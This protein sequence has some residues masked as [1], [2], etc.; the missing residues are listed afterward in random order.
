MGSTGGPLHHLLIRCTVRVHVH[1]RHAGTGFF[2]APGRV[3]TCAHVVA[4]AVREGAPVS[5]VWQA[6]TFPAEVLKVLPKVTDASPYPYPD[7]A[8]LSVECGRHPC[9][10]LG[11]GEPELGPPP[12]SLWAYGFTKELDGACVRGTPASFAYEGPVPDPIPDEDGPRLQLKAA[13]VVPGMS[14]APLLNWRTGQVCGIVT[15]TRDARSD[16][17]GWAVPVAAALEQIDGL[18]QAHDAFHAEDHEWRLAVRDRRIPTLHDV[19]RPPFRPLP[20]GA[21]RS[22]SVVLWPEHGVVAFRGRHDEL[23][24][25]A[26][27]CADPAAPAVRL[28]VGPGGRGKS[29]LAAELC[30]R[31]GGRGW[32]AGLL[33][34]DAADDALEHVRQLGVP[35]LVVIDYAETRGN[36]AR[37]LACLAEDDPAAPVRVLLLAREA[38]D[39]WRELLG[40][41]GDVE[42]AVAGAAVRRLGEV[43]ETVEGRGEAFD[44]AVQAFADAQGVV[45]GSVTRPPLSG[46]TFTSI[47]FVHL[48]ALDALDGGGERAAGTAGK[49]R[50][51]LLSSLLQREARFWAGTARVRGLGQLADRVLRRAVAVATLVGADGE[52]QAALLLAK[53]PDLCDASQALLR[54]DVAWWLHDLYPGQEWLRPLQPDLLGETLVA[55]VLRECPELAHAV[56]ADVAGA[57][58]ERA[59]TVLGRAARH[60]P[61]A[62]GTLVAVLQSDFARL[63]PAALTVAVQVGD[64][65]G[66]AL[67]EAARGTRP[68]PALC[69][70]LLDQVPQYTV[71]LRELAV[72]LTEWLLQAARAAG[73]PAETARLL[74]N[75]SNRLADL[76]RHEQ[77]LDAIQEAAALHR[78]LAETR[79]DAFTPD[80]ARSLNNLSGRLADLGRHEQALAARQEAARITDRP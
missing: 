2:V 45:A 74:N 73:E 13:K 47:L 26:G 68:D 36:L 3:L 20:A 57:R 56:F 31:M 11:V 15:R 23:A 7:T 1:G 46:S 9:V 70:E 69:A 34:K 39:W 53:V 48:A 61:S 77:A 8:L 14:G 43:D 33:D 35:A 25:L 30:R 54:R 6:A 40:A 32:A 60:Q 67:A 79:P 5:V 59:L 24:E 44:Q 62:T 80:L 51:Q 41:G 16:V 17:G 58:A 64:P 21:A 12:D 28:I 38:G 27:W 66:Q 72:V 18:R 50:E 49:T 52:A 42:L 63:A 55:Q 78:T 10:E 4:R 75:L 71:A 65:V 29:R 19:L 76:G 37:L 22:P